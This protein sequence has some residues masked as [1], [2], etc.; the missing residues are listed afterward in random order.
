MFNVLKAGILIFWDISISW[1]HLYWQ[2]DL[3]EARGT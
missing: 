3:M 1:V 2:G